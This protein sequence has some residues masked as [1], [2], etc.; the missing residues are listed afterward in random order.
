[1]V[2]RIFLPSCDRPV[3]L[4]S[5]AISSKLITLP[6]FL[7]NISAITSSVGVS[8]TFLLPNHSVLVSEISVKILEG[9]SDSVVL[10]RRKLVNNRETRSEMF[11]GSIIQ[12]DTI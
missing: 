3:I 2:T 1:M 9:V 4:K 7:K 11:K 12:S 5:R 6:K 8:S 10:L